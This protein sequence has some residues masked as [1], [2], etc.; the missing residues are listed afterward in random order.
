MKSFLKEKHGSQTLANW[1][2][3]QER[4]S[5]QTERLARD[6]SC[7]IEGPTSINK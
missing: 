6:V 3:E 7:W 5:Q 4:V 1:E 2:E